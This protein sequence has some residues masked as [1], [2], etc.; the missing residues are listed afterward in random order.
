MTRFSAV[1]TPTIVQSL[2]TELNAGQVQ[3][4]NNLGQLNYANGSE[5]DAAWAFVTGDTLHLFVAGNLAL[6]LNVQGNRTIGHIL[7]VFVD[8]APGGFSNISAGPGHPIPPAG[9]D[10]PARG[11]AQTARSA[12]R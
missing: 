1:C 11:P 9:A 8:S 4:D 2:Q 10:P 3:G 12:R 5:I 7:D 6:V